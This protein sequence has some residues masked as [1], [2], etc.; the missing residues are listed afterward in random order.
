[1]FGSSDV[2]HEAWRPVKYLRGHDSDV[3]DLAWSADNKYLASCG[4]DGFVIV[5]SGTTFG[6]ESRATVNPICIINL[7]TTEQITKI[8][9]HSDFVKGVTWDPAGKFLASQ[10]NELVLLTEVIE[11]I[12]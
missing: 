9:Q 4:V 1:M 3:Q 11:L 8:D 2:N 6:K 7:Y 12:N 5:W 10:V